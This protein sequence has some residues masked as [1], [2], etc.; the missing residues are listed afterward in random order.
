VSLAGTKAGQPFYVIDVLIDV[1][2]AAA[3]SNINAS[4]GDPFGQHTGIGL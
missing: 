4:Q 1:E 3:R 2:E